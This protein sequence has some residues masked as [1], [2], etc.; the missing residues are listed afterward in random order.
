MQRRPVPT[1]AW[2]G[3]WR[4]CSGAA[5]PPSAP[6]E[7]SS[8]CIWRRRRGSSCQCCWQRRTTARGRERARA[9]AGERGKVRVL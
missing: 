1:F 8:A 7:Q 4:L 9:P 5:L 2:A 6:G 3:V